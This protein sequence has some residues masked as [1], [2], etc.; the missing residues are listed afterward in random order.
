MPDLMRN[1]GSVVSVNATL[2]WIG[3]WY[4]ARTPISDTVVG[5]FEGVEIEEVDRALSNMLR[6]LLSVYHRQ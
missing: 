2:Q 1:R 6:P 4:E 5:V 3:T